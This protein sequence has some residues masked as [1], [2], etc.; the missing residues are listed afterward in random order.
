MN[1]NKKSN[2][3][4]KIAHEV[5][6]NK[7]LSLK[8]VGLIIVVGIVVISISKFVNSVTDLVGA[9]PE[10]E[11]TISA[12]DT[13]TQEQTL[14]AA[15]KIDEIFSKILPVGNT[16]SETYSYRG[17]KDNYRIIDVELQNLLLRQESRPLNTQSVKQHKLVITEFSKF[18]EQHK[19]E[20]INYAMAREK[21]KL[22]HEMFKKIL[23]LEA[24]KPKT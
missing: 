6:L 7:F 3:S 12:Y 21:R 9:L 11:A 14:S 4:D 13:K 22:F 23:S 16:G 10:P 5:F 15:K 20:N 1:A 2:S 24:I 17:L 18:I 8:F 19:T